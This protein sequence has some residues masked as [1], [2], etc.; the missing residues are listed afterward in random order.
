MTLALEDAPLDNR[1][2]AANGFELAVRQAKV[3]SM[4]SEWEPWSTC[5]LRHGAGVSADR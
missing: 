2:L 4:P 3:G 5:A 1:T